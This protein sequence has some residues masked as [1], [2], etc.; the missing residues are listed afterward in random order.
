M[1]RLLLAPVVF[2]LRALIL[3]LLTCG[4]ATT[5]LAQ[6][7]ELLIRPSRGSRTIASN[8]L[9]QDLQSQMARLVLLCY[10]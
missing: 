10:V 4:A 3:C 7:I 9:S 1:K 8:P 5:S 2:S 6:D